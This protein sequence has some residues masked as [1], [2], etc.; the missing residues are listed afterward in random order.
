MKNKLFCLWNIFVP[1][2]NGLAIGLYCLTVCFVMRYAHLRA[3]CKTAVMEHL[4][5]LV[6]CFGGDTAREEHVTLLS[7]QRLRYIPWDDQGIQR[8]CS[9]GNVFLFPETPVSHLSCGWR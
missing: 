8:F 5:I 9:S 6:L 7:V 4:Q 2:P 1:G 3:W